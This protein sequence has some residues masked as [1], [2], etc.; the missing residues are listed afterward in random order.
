MD[1]KKKRTYITFSKKQIVSVK[2]HHDSNVIDTKTNEVMQMYTIRLPSKH[3]RLTRF[4]EDGQGIN[5]DDRTA[6]ISLGAPYVF[7]NENNQDIFY[8][9]PSPD[10]EYTVNFKGHVL[11]K[12]DNNKNIFDKPESVKITGEKLIA[13]FDEAKEISKKKNRELKKKTEKQKAV[14]NKEVKKAEKAEMV[15]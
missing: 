2:P 15:K 12:D 4:G 7:Q 13:I 3:Y 10:R 8:S 11:G 6:T 14:E 9:Y 1:K 5:R